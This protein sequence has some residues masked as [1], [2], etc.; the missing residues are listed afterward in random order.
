VTDG[1]RLAGTAD[2]D[3]RRRCLADQARQAIE[4]GIDVIQIRERDLEAAAL[5]QL[6]EEMISLAQ[7]SATRVVVNDRLDVALACGAAGVHLR[8]DSVTAAAAR[9]MTPSGFLVGRSV[10]NERE[11][12]GSLPGVD[13]LIAGTVWPSA[14]KPDRH[15]TLGV[16]GLARVAAAVDVPIIAI[17]GVTIERFAAVAAAGARGAAG[18]GLFTAGGLGVIVRAARAAFDTPGSAS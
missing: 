18:I 8:G 11:A 1:R 9:R 6:V 3:V 4:A 16:A 5:A 12:A 2:P 17:G 10:H 15:A 13:Y 7:G 14:S